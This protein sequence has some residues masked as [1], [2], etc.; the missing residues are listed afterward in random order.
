MFRNESVII[1]PVSS[2]IHIRDP[3]EISFFAF[4]LPYG[5]VPVPYHVVPYRTVAYRTEPY[6]YR[7]VS[8]SY[9]A[10][11]IANLTFALLGSLRMR[12]LCFIDSERYFAYGTVYDRTVNLASAL[13]LLLIFCSCAP[14]RDRSCGRV[15]SYRGLFL[16]VSQRIR[17]NPPVFFQNT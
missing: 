1:R 15:S 4:P 3:Y 7:T 2:K 13:F 10:C 12:Y 9:Y 14:T 11:S 17:N 6:C 8:Q 5:T 16:Y